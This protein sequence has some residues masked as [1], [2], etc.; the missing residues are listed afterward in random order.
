[1][2]VF[3]KKKKG[4]IMNVLPYTGLFWTDF[5]R[6]RHGCTL[7]LPKHPSDH[8]QIGQKLEFNQGFK[9]KF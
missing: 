9:E 1:M 6:N 2:H 8:T 4:K 3:A 5:D 7:L